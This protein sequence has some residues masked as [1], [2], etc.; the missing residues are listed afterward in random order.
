MDGIEKISLSDS[1]LSKPCH[2]LPMM[3]VGTMV[4]VKMFKSLLPNKMPKTN[5]VNQDLNIND[6]VPSDQD[7]HC[8][9]FQQAF[10]R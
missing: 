3:I 4:N 8:W 5:S 6:A 2:Q 9:L 7:I 10:L 1:S